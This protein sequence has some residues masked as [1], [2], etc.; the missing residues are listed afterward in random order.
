MVLTKECESHWW[1]LSL[2]SVSEI[3]RFTLFPTIRKTQPA[4]EIHG[5]PDLSD[6]FC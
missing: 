6:E 5:R 2:P 1:D 3:I 4:A